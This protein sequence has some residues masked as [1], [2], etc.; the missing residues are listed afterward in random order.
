MNVTADRSPAI[1]SVPPGNLGYRDPAGRCNWTLYQNFV[2]DSLQQ[3]SLL[4]KF[5]NIAISGQNF[6]Q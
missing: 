5:R 3:L 1:T 6:L 2:S 4:Q